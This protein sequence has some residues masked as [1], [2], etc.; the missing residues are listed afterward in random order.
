MAGSRGPPIVSM[1]APV[2]NW[3]QDICHCWG[4]AS[5]ATN[6]SM[7]KPPLSEIVASRVRQHR[8][9]RNWSQEQLAEAAGI[10]RDALSRIERNDRAAR[11]DTVAAIADALGIEVGALLSG[12]VRAAKSVGEGGEK[13][14]ALEVLALRSLRA[15]RPKVASAMVRVLSLVARS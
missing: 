5:W 8:K 4:V 6:A 10:S 12:A 2:D 14:G 3:R 1:T 11:L 9:A 15:M 13:Q 7:R